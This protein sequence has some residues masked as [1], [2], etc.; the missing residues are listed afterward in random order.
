M[1]SVGGYGLFAPDGHNTVCAH[2]FAYE[3]LIG[4]IPDGLQLDHLCQ[5]SRCVN[6]YHLDPV[7]PRVNVMRSNNSAGINSRKTQCKRGH[8]FDETN[9]GI[10]GRGHRF[11]LT[12]RRTAYPRSKQAAA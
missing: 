11:C 4:P 5:N 10:N 12:C 9:T 6:P 8:V 7:T 1:S 3:D 2:R